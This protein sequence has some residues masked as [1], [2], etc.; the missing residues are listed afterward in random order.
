MAKLTDVKLKALIRDGKPAAVSD[1]D[2]LTF[3]LSRARTAAWILR[4]RHGG[5][6]R[7]MTIG[8]YPDMGL[9]KARQVAAELRVQIQ[10]GRDVAKDKQDIRRVR[11]A[12]VPFSNLVEDYMA[13]VFPKLA[14]ST[15]KQRRRYINKHILPHLG[16]IPVNEVSARDVVELVERVGRH[17]IHVAEIVFTAISEIFKHGIGRH[18]VVANPT[19]GLSVSAISGMPAP[20]KARLK[21]SADELAAVAP[22]LP[23]LGGQNAAAVRLLLLTCVRICEL[24]QA[25]WDHVD[26]DEGLWTVPAEVGKTSV[27]FVVPLTSEAVDC[28]RHLKELAG[29]SKFVLP[30]RQDRRRRNFGG[31]IYCEQRT[32]NR[33]L[34]EL[35][36][37]LKGTVRRFTPH[38]LRSTARSH[39]GAL[40]VDILVAERCLNHSLGGLVA[41]YDQH[42]YLD[43]RRAA[44]E[45]WSAVLRRCGMFRDGPAELLEKGPG[46]GE[47]KQPYVE[48]QGMGDPR[49]GGRTPFGTAG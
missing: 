37:R 15:V 49:A 20:S 48:V 6:Q 5:R 24:T 29:N 38:D 9:A 47:R 27:A 43:E 19:L 7:E 11:F 22:M 40:G 31:D 46:D 34:T 10:L 18:A 41:I 39:L 42:D 45:K 35:H 13:K 16:S 26:L 23:S 14:D 17:S 2:G 28:F 33:A 21:L 12:E 36:H 4:Y 1:G 8:R 44:L 3:T 30:A 32:L 25:E